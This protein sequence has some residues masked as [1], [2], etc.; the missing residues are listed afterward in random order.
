VLAR[1]VPTQAHKF[2]SAE[3]KSCSNV[4][5]IG[6]DHFEQLLCSELE[7]N[8]YTPSVDIVSATHPHTHPFL[9]SKTRYVKIGFYLFTYVYFVMY[10]SLANLVKRIVEHKFL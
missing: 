8:C 3:R 1:G 9:P 5:L 6:A 4:L 7:L 2:S 10:S